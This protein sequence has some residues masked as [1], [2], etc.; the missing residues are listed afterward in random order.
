MNALKGSR[1][2]AARL[3]STLLG[4]LA[5]LAS[6]HPD[7]ISV[8]ED[9]FVTV[10][11]HDS[12]SRYDSVTIQLLAAAD[13]DQV[14]GSVWNGR[15]PAPGAV[16]AYRLDEGETRDLAVR[17]RGYDATGRLVFETLISKV[18][19]NQ[20]VTN[21]VFP[22]LSPSL[23]SLDM[24]PG[25]LTPAFSPEVKE[26]TASLAHGQTSVSLT[27]VPEYA[28]ASILIGFIK[29][30]S[31]KPSDTIPMRVGENRITVSVTSPDTSTQYIVTATRAAAPPDTVVD[32]DPDPDPDPNPDPFILDWKHR[33]VVILNTNQ[34]GMGENAIVTEFPLLIRL[35]QDNFDF[36]QAWTDGRDIRFATSRGKI[37]PHEVMRWDAAKAYARIW[38]R[39]DT[40]RSDDAGDPILMYWGNANAASASDPG[41]V[42]P[43]EADWTG[44]WHLEEAGKGVA[45][46]YKDA[47][48]QAHGTSCHING[49]DPAR[50]DGAVGYA[51]DFKVTNQQT[52]IS[53][54]NQFDPGDES[55]SVHMWVKHPGGGSDGSIFH[56][57]DGP[58]PNQQRFRINSLAG[59]R[60]NLN[61][62]GADYFTSIWFPQD[63]WML[64]GIVY[65]GRRARVYID[66]F[67]REASDWTQ[68]TNAFAKTFL[69]AVDAKGTMGF[70][71][72]L[73]ELWFS[74]NKRTAE[75]MRLI[76][77]N[78]KAYSTFVTIFPL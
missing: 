78:Q 30:K 49:S 68:G 25:T 36:S 29:A 15:L 44:V 27:V 9:N 1:A 51:Q 22:K 13:T 11:L 53:L 54:P 19:G 34:V 58:N 61:R 24:V 32:P 72:T 28:D 76:F 48:G 3:I 5:L 59:G 12:L 50:K 69:G 17:V 2:L 8:R 38:V 55:W 20:V 47:S 56:K 18:D 39:L 77:E 26:Y 66:G 70:T 75:Y 37:L 40:L 46:E 4:C 6:C 57:G 74:S 10:K 67:E 62:I 41:K 65:D 7:Q 63:Y 31:G 35:N 45:G 73:D 16:P 42:F 21:V 14:V 60:L 33:A 52:A 71:G 64:V 23:A 43:P